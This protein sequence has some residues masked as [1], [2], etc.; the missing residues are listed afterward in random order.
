[1][2]NTKRLFLAFPINDQY[3]ELITE[4]ISLQQIQKIRWISKQNWHVTVL[5]LGD[6]PEDHIPYLSTSLQKIFSGCH[7]F[8][9]NFDGFVYKPKQARPNMIWARFHQHSYFDLLCKSLDDQMESL[10]ADLS[11]PFS[12]SLHSE[13]IPHITLSRLKNQYFRYPDLIKPT[14]QVHPHT[15]RCDFC[16][17]FQSVLSSE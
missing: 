12:M 3:E 11:L 7:S 4:F 8:S 16:I 2:K 17:L 1:M 6:F 14:K 5:F 9:L 13:N 15:L 10:Y